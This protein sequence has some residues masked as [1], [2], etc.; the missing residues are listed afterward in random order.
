[1]GALVILNGLGWFFV[2]PTLTT[3]EQDTGIQLAGFISE[4]PEAAYLLSLQ[5]RNTAILLMGIGLLGVGRVLTSLRSRSL[6]GQLSGWIFGITL[7]GV[8]TAE[9][10]AGA[11]FGFAY[12]GLGILTFLGQGLFGR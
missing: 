7:A 3:F 4:Y 1:M 2:G 10:L 6:A 12:L 5:A 8:G 11:Q 9:L